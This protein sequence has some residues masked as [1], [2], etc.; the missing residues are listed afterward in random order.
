[1]RQVLRGW[2]AI[3]L[4]V[5]CLRSGKVSACRRVPTGRRRRHDH[6]ALGVYETAGFTRTEA[7]WALSTVVQFV[8][9]TA[10]G[11]AAGNASRRRQGLNAANHEARLR[12]ATAQATVISLPPRQF[13]WVSADELRRPRGSLSRGRL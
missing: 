6:H 4:H 2:V 13:G 10:M 1:L 12:Q 8:L 9:G 5:E 3:R 7:D 11:Q